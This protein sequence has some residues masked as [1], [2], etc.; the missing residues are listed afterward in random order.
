MFALLG[1]LLVL[2]I[3]CII[4]GALVKTIGWLLIIGIIGL[5]AT[6]LFGVFQALTSRRPNP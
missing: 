1:L 5:V 3:A 2:W 4:I 6:A